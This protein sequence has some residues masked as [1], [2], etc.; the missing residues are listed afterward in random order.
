[1]SYDFINKW[2]NWSK[3]SSELKSLKLPEQKE[4]VPELKPF[5][6]SDAARGRP[7]PEAVKRVDTTPAAASPSSALPNI[8]NQAAATSQGIGDVY[9]NT[10]SPNYAKMAASHEIGLLIELMN[11]G[12]LCGNILNMR[13]R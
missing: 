1:M 9:T 13:P 11:S 4:S 10:S 7:H 8:T 3:R 6:I 2:A 12:S 5:S